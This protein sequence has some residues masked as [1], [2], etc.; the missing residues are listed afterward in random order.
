[1]SEEL[2]TF[3]FERANRVSCRRTPQSQ[4][5]LPPPRMFEGHC[6]FVFLVPTLTILHICPPF[7]FLPSNSTIVEEAIAAVAQFVALP[8][9]E[10]TLDGA[11][12]VAAM[13][14][15]ANKFLAQSS[16]AILGDS[17]SSISKDGETKEALKN[18][19][20]ELKGDSVH[21]THRGDAVLQSPDRIKKRIVKARRSRVRVRSSQRNLGQRSE[22]KDQS[23]SK[24]TAS[25]GKKDKE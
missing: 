12:R 23:P 21:F 24:G 18:Q 13:M 4:L 9:P 8:E 7:E 22:R 25:L 2:T 3:V 20:A 1:M 10:K 17:Q 11:K 15:N 14:D 6:F 19:M 16:E 5:D